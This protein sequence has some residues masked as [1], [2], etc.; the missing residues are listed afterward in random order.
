MTALLGGPVCLAAGR[1]ASDRPGSRSTTRPFGAVE[2]EVGPAARRRAADRRGA[3]RVRQRPQSRLP[4]R[5][6]RP[7]P[8]RR[9]HLLDLAAS[10]CTPSRRAS[11][12][13]ATSPSPG[14]STPRWCWPA[15]PRSGSSTTCTTSRGGRPYADPNAMGAA[16]IAGRR[17][18]RHPAHPAGHLLPRRRADRR[19]SPS[20]WTRCSARFGDGDVEAWAE[21][22][23]DLRDG[24]TTPDRG[25]PRT[26]SARCRRPRWPPWPRAA[27]DRP[28]HVHL[29]EQPAENAATQAYYGCTPDRAAR[30]A[31]G[32]SGPRTT[33]VH[34]THL[35]D[36]D[37]ALLG[38]RRHR[39]LLLPDH[40]TGPRRRHRPAGGLRGRRQPA[41]PRLR[42]ST[43]SIDP[44]EELRGLEMH[45]R[46]DQPAARPVHP[47]RADRPR[48][49]AAGLHAAWAGRRAA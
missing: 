37:I 3:A 20:R 36:A 18:G 19:R 22:V 39:L 23:A 27:G 44:F 38:R 7:H 26:R 13:T 12:P 46:L 2:P 11:I 8:R 28:L 6:A 40:R 35:S 24:P 45:E 42:L 32:A 10:R 14:R 30:D 33:A 17:R 29:S 47:G 34:A 49:R 15:T 1:A 25:R 31:R 48:R 43:R 41:D 21:R 9:R 4:P 16:L 5:P